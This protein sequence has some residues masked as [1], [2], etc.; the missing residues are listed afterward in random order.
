MRTSQLLLVFL[1]TSILALLCPPVVPAA[2]AQDDEFIEGDTYDDGSGGAVWAEDEYEQ[3]EWVDGEPAEEVD[4][5]YFFDKLAP[6]GEWIWTP[7]YGW[8]WRP[9]GVAADWRPYTYGHWVYTEFGWTWASSFEWGW[10]PFHYGSWAYL[11]H[12]GWVWVP[13]RVWAPARVIWRYSG[14]HVGWA[15]ILAGYDFWFGWAYYP[16]YYSHWTFISWHNF[17][18]RHPHHHYVNRGRVKDV[19]RHSYYP[20]RCRDSAGRGCHRGP[21]RKAVQRVTHTRIPVHKIENVARNQR[22]VRR[23]SKKLGVAGDRLRVFRPRFKPGP[24]RIGTSAL[25]KG[26]PSRVRS[27]DLGVVQS[28]RQGRP[29]GIDRPGMA[30]PTPSSAQV[31]EFPAATRRPKPG[32]TIHP[33][34]PPRST[35]GGTGK[36]L[37]PPKTRQYR[38]SPRIPTVHSPS[39][40]PG[41][42]SRPKVRNKTNT[43]R[44]PK[45]TGRSNSKPSRSYSKP[46]SS[47]KTS[48]PSSSRRSSGSS[49]SSRS[50]SSRR[51]SSRGSKRR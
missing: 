12:I 11:D 27:V 7:E 43:F 18:D 44:G 10:A 2:L 42:R 33:R 40:T 45:S 25:K 9:T 46:S 6:F 41:S 37:K 16:V 50:S 28:G 17:C 19:F 48:R 39:K 20:R 34:R 30:K 38:P 13:G 26:S 8:V 22:D 24:Q 21:S 5:N 23:A 1:A 35:R 47:K 14:P 36:G 49:K 32:A 51:S 3:E 29:A 31:S 15:P 4:I